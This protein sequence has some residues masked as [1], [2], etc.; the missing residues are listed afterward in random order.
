MGRG[1]RREGEEERR[2]SI[3]TTF[4]TKLS[5]V[6]SEGSCTV[7]ELTE[8]SRGGASLA[9]NCEERQEQRDT[10]QLWLLPGGASTTQ[11]EEVLPLLRQEKTRCEAGEAS[12]RLDHSRSEHWQ[13]Y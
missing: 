2:S 5:E 9:G 10:E 4:Q 12:E 11:E 1:G 8:R 13:T 7:T 6:G 3:T